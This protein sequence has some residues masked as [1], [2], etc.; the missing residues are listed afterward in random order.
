MGPHLGPQWPPGEGL[1]L[2][3]EGGFQAPALGLFGPGQL[4]PELQVI[5]LG[6]GSSLNL[7]ALQALR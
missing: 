2:L 6:I 3:L 1:Q 7:Q 5:E 4:L